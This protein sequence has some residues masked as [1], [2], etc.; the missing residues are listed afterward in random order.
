MSLKC[1]VIYQ[2]IQ[3]KL[4]RRIESFDNNCP[5]K[6]NK[7]NE[8]IYNWKKVKSLCKKKSFN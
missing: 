6:K 7:S 4:K 8:F 2:L 1:N 5:K 3:N